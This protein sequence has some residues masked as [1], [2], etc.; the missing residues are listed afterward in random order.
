[1]TDDPTLAVSPDN[2]G[3]AST[4][5]I[6]FTLTRICGGGKSVTTEEHPS[7]RFGSSSNIEVPLG[8]S[9]VERVRDRLCHLLL[10][11][12]QRISPEIRVLITL[13]HL[14]SDILRCLVVRPCQHRGLPLILRP[15]HHQD[16]P[17]PDSL[18]DI[19]V[20]IT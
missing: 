6:A 2:S 1:M 11:N 14:G 4:V 18:L 13:N 5:I 19:Q 20:L 7:E 15:R 9:I 8:W 10:R 3:L 16:R 17:D 12:S